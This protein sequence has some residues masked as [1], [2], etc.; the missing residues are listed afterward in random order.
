MW[1]KNYDDIMRSDRFRHLSGFVLNEDG[2]FVNSV[3]VGKGM[4]GLR[5]LDWKGSMCSESQAHYGWAQ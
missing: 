2:I 1:N 4:K 3:L 5:V